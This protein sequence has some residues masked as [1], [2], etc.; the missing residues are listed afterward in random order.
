MGLDGLLI[1]VFMFLL[2]WLSSL[3][4]ELLMSFLLFRQVL[5]RISIRILLKTRL[6]F[7]IFHWYIPILYLTWISIRH[8]QIIVRNNLK[9]Q[10]IFLSKLLYLNFFLWLLKKITYLWLRLFLRILGP[11]R[12]LSTFFAFDWVSNSLGPISEGFLGN[13]IGLSVFLFLRILALVFYLVLEFLDLI[14]DL[15]DSVFVF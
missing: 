6:I 9:R 1:F 4:L 10:L 11:Y 15:W 5:L 13:F 14:Y 7:S 12:F 2:F 3:Y 8:K